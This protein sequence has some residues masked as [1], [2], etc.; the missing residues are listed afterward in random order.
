MLSPFA[1]RSS[2]PCGR[3]LCCAGHPLHS[4]FSRQGWFI[5]ISPI[6]RLANEVV[7][8]KWEEAKPLSPYGIHME[9]CC[10]APIWSE[11]WISKMERRIGMLNFFLDAAY[12]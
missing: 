8:M 7:V 5:L 12:Q 6:F 2:S 3:V 4:Y 10:L 11:P 1:Y 9:E